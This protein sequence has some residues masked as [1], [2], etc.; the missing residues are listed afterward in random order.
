MVGG[1]FIDLIQR[2]A[3]MCR[4]VRHLRCATK[5]SPASQIMCDDEKVSLNTASSYQ[6][7]MFNGK[8]TG[9]VLALGYYNYSALIMNRIHQS[10]S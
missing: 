7:V 6:L 9:A 10:R 1:S 8:T 4:V 3:F 5:T 2:D